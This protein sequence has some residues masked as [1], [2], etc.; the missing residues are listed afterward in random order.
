MPCPLFRINFQSSRE[1]SNDEMSNPIPTPA[2]PILVFFQ[3]VKSGDLRK[4]EARSNDST[5]GGG[6]RDLRMPKRFWDSVAP[7]FPKEVSSRER[8][9]II[10][11]ETGQTIQRVE[12]S[13]WRPTGARPS[14]IRIGKIT[15][16][17]AW[18]I[19]EDYFA[20]ELQSDYLL[21]YLLTLDVN[22][23]VWAR[24]MSTRYLNA[25]RK[26]FSDFVRE[27]TAEKT[28]DSKTARGVF[29]FANGNH[30]T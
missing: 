23:R 6:A 1:F 4:Q 9:G 14:E 5:T 25:N 7:F 29:D 22:Q 27:V 11:S 12:T 30:Y 10:I 21:F 28:S 18:T 20:S 2:D 16:I 15:L 13:F 19:E 24:T 8:S 17:D 3:E 26:D